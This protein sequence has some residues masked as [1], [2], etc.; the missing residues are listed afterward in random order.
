MKGSQQT[1]HK[2]GGG[3]RDYL[4]A[5]QVQRL[6]TSRQREDLAAA[7]PARRTLLCCC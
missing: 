3:R 2:R 1:Q 4:L 7:F 6:F 5:F